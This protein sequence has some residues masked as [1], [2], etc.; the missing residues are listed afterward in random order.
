TIFQ[1]RQLRHSCP[2][3]GCVEEMTG[4]VMVTDSD[5]PEDVHPLSIHA[6]GR[7]AIQIDWSDGHNTGIYTWERLHELARRWE[8]SPE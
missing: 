4:R 8:A 5:V 3:A 7:Y 1:A 2:C 6:V